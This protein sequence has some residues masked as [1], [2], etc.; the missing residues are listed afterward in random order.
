[1]LNI[2]RRSSQETTLRS[3]SFAIQKTKVRA[4]LKKIV[5]LV[6]FIISYIA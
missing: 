2:L 4:I 1:M 6:H 5:Y 3:R